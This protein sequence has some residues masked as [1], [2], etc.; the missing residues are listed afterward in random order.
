[1]L[2]RRFGKT[3]LKMP[4]LT[5]G[6]MPAKYSWQEGE[7]GL[8]PPDNQEN[9]QAVVERALELGINHIETARAYGTSE[10]QLQRVLQSIPISIRHSFVP[11]QPAE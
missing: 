7:I 5:A 10:R 6:M 1:M 3:G 9:L 4:L 11:G 2:C 8:V